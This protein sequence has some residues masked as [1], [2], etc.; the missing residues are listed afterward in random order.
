MELEEEQAYSKQGKT[1]PKWLIRTLMESKLT[2]PLQVK[3]RSTNQQVEVHYVHLD[4]LL[5]FVMRSHSLADA[6]AYNDW[7]EAMNRAHLQEQHLGVM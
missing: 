2:S 7:V 5:K 3:T 1:V 4:L 6:L